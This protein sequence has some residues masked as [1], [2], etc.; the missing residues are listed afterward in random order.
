MSNAAQNSL[1]GTGVCPG[2]DLPLRAFRVV[3]IVLR[4]SRVGE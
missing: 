4:A 2:R 3:R 1:D